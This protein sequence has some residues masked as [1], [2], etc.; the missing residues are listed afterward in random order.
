V[1]PIVPFFSLLTE[2]SS[3][4]ISFNLTQDGHQMRV[5]FN[6]KSFE[7]TLIE[8]PCTSGAMMG[9]P[10]HRMRM[11][12]P[13]KEIDELMCRLWADDKRP[14]IRH[15]RIAKKINPHELGEMRKFDFHPS[16]SMVEVLPGE[17]ILSHQE[18]TSHCPIHHMDNRDF[19]GRKDFNA[20]HSS[21]DQPQKAV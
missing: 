6:R 8:V 21:H 7:T 12:Q 1:V 16:L 11:R 20:S 4:R 17:L 3:Q 5:F 18:A 9:V 2:S 10:T 14:V 15:N 13:A 19:V